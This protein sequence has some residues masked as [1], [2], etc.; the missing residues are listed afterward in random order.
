[1]W[2]QSRSHF[3]QITLP[4]HPFRSIKSAR[5]I[6]WPFFDLWDHGCIY[7]IVQRNSQVIFRTYQASNISSKRP[8]GRNTPI[9]AQKFQISTS[10]SRLRFLH[11][12]RRW[13]EWQ[14]GINNRE[15]HRHPQKATRHRTSMREMLTAPKG[16]AL[17]H[18]PYLTVI[19]FEASYL[20]LWHFLT[21]PSSEN[22]SP[23]ASQRKM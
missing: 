7:H 15:C 10:L 8:K 14:S 17:F 12:L 4:I 5:P 9:M 18:N 20:S 19:N 16:T 1:M 11:A 6:V 22:V 3:S 21:T 13:H 23:G 2:E